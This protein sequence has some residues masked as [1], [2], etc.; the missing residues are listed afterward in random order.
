[1]SLSTSSWRIDM[2]II[3]PRQIIEAI[4]LMFGQQADDLGGV[5]HWKQSEVRALLGLLDQL[6]RDLVTLP[7][8]DSLEFERCRAILATALPKWDMHGAQ[9]AS[10][11]SKNPVERIR[12]LLINCPNEL[13][14]PEPEFPFVTD[15][16]I[17]LGIEDRTRAAWIDF[18]AKEWLGATTSAAVALE[19]VLL[20]EIKR[21]PEP[22]GGD[23]R[24][25]KRK[26]RPDDMI[27][28]ELIDEARALGSISEDAAKQAHLARDARNLI[29]PGKVARSGASCDKA[30]ALTAFA[31]VYH[32]TSELGRAFRTRQ[33]R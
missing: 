29:H 7:F 30:T 1:M 9:M 26:K 3:T 17:R 28:A 32:V 10:I 8:H 2:P 33:N 11:E 4:N 14:P 20:W 16:D 12:R 13:P 21:F 15:N 24:N 25:S 23:A 5:P 27:L 19:A 18:N 31:G 6:P 22:P